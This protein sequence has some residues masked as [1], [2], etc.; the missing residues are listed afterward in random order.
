M[1][2]VN[3]ML[4]NAKGY[5]KLLNDADEPAPDVASALREIDEA[6]AEMVAIKKRLQQ[7]EELSDDAFNAF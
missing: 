6:L 4:Q 3:E 2:T 1:K 7:I 5:L